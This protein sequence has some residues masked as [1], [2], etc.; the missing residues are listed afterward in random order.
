M[1]KKFPKFRMI[2][3]FLV[4]SKNF[5]QIL[6]RYINFSYILRQYLRILTHPIIH[7]LHFL[8]CIQFCSI[9]IKIFSP[10]TQWGGLTLKTPLSAPLDRG[11]TSKRNN[12]RKNEL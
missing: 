5:L 7:F 12:R 2:F 11:L 10:E 6:H 4:M 3:V 8:H 1:S 9:Y